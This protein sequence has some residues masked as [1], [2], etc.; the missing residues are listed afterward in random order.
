MTVNENEQIYLFFDMA[1]T[2]RA[3]VDELICFSSPNLKAALF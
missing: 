1:V 2:D 3:W